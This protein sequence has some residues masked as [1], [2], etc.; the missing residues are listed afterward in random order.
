MLDINPSIFLIGSLIAGGI[1]SILLILSVAFMIAKFFTK[2]PI[3]ERLDKI[4]KGLDETQSNM[5]GLARK[6]D[7]DNLSSA[8]NR[9]NETLQGVIR[10][11]R[12][13]RRKR[14]Q[15]NVRKPRG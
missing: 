5:K 15:E 2:A 8:I 13:D 6:E 14:R 12:K 10:I 4:Q 9:L 7:I 11:K 3:I 1:G